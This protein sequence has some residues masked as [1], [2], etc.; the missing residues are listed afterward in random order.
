MGD[1]GLLG[2]LKKHVFRDTNPGDSGFGS[3]S[4]SFPGKLRT[5]LSLPESVVN[6]VQLSTLRHHRHRRLR[7]GFVLVPTLVFLLDPDAPET[8]PKRPELNPTRKRTRTVTTITGK[9]EDL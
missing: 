6:L 9:I 5:L 8:K 4:T 1:H 3:Q 2:I 7:F